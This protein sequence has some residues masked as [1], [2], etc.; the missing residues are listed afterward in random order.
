MNIINR[1]FGRTPSP[2]MDTLSAQRKSRDPAVMDTGKMTESLKEKRRGVRL[3]APIVP[4]AEDLES[5][6]KTES[7]IQEAGKKIKLNKFVY[8]INPLHWFDWL[9]LKKVKKSEEIQAVGETKAVEAKID[10]KKAFNDDTKKRLIKDLMYYLG[11]KEQ[12]D[13]KKLIEVEG[14][15]RISPATS[16]KDNVWISLANAKVAQ[17][18]QDLDVH[19]ATSMI[20][21]LLGALNPISEEGINKFLEAADPAK[22]PEEKDALLRQAVEIGIKGNDQQF[23]LELMDFFHDVS[24]KAWDN[25]MPASNL[26]VPLMPMLYQ[27]NVDDISTSLQEMSKFGVGLAYFI[28]NFNKIYPKAEAEEESDESSKGEVSS[29]DSSIVNVDEAELISR[30]RNRL[31]S[32]LTQEDKQKLADEIN[33]FEAEKDRS[34]K[35]NTK[36]DES[37]SQP[38]DI[39]PL[40]HEEPLNPISPASKRK[41]VETREKFETQ[42]PAPQSNEPPKNSPAANEIPRGMVQ[43]L[44]KK[45]EKP[46]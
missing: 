13:G 26:A 36:I 21:E 42:A 30:K 31:L 14:V 25:K 4:T 32:Q 20:K 12:A 8:Y 35:E 2:S 33:A 34:E 40:A 1:L 27:R 18:P 23:F 43:D 37:D 6:Q 11:H 46:L 15:F 29:E 39:A 19:I 38:K 28:E 9:R 24:D 7:F 45:F 5:G 10:L 41:F 22:S 17:I 3:E 44:K 16:E